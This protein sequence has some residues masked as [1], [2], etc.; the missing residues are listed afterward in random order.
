VYGQ[1]EVT[2]D[3]YAARE[4]MGAR[5]EFEVEDV[6]IEGI[7]GDGAT[8]SYTQGGNRHSIRCDYVAGCDGYHGVSRKTIPGAV[9]FDPFDDDIL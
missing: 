7:E 9:P 8:V 5:L 2:R 3:L 6:V 1:T 4:A